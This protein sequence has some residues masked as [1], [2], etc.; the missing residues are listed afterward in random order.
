[1][2]RIGFPTFGHWHPDPGAQTRTAPGALRPA[3]ELARA[4]A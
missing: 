4:A 1:M 3:I 2:K